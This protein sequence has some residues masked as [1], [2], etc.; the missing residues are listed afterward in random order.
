MWLTISVHTCS[1]FDTGRCSINPIHFSLNL[2][3]CFCS[4]NMHFLCTK[5]CSFGYG[6]GCG[7]GGDGGGWLQCVMMS[8][9]NA[10]NLRDELPHVVYHHHHHHREHEHAF[11]SLL[12][13]LLFILL[14]SVCSPVYR[15]IFLPKYTSTQM[16]VCVRV[17]V[18][19]TSP[20]H[21][22]RTRLQKRVFPLN[23]SVVISRVPAKRFNFPARFRPVCSVQFWHFDVGP[24]FVRVS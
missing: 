23:Q 13:L 21:S 2:I 4:Q 10:F 22:Q 18:I 1:K 5:S 16:C 14:L 19:R 12:L 20:I 17:F 9:F 24:L 6:R 8:P 7:G 11:I 15:F 3:R